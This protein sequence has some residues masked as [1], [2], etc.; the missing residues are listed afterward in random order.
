MQLSKLIK[1]KY[2]NWTAKFFS[3]DAESIQIDDIMLS[4]GHILLFIP[5]WSYHGQKLK[6]FYIENFA[7]DLPHNT[8]IRTDISKYFT[9][10]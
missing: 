7:T 9:L 10:K 1:P 2:F 4:I 8:M 3:K 6:K 5:C